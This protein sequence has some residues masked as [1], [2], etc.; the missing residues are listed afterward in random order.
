[1]FLFQTNI[2]YKSIIEKCLNRIMK[3]DENKG[4]LQVTFL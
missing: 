2:A 4:I 3:E 1:M